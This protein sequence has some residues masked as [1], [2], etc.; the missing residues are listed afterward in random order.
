[1]SQNVTGQ[2]QGSTPSDNSQSGAKQRHSDAIRVAWITAVGAV[3]VAVIG[4]VS[5]FA[6]GLIKAGEAI[7]GPPDGS[8]SAAAATG[9]G[10]PKAGPSNLHFIVPPTPKVARRGIYQGTGNIPSGYDLLV[11]NRSVD[12][13]HQS[14]TGTYSMDGLATGTSSGWNTPPVCAGTTYVEI[15]AVLV[16]S[17]TTRFLKSIIPVVNNVETNGSW[18]SGALP[19]GEKVEPSIFVEPDLSKSDAD[20]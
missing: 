20:C 15:T 12:A 17:S 14:D 18:V 9:S 4:A 5:A 11:F 3:I 16:P 1:V 13:D 19:A 2:P 10:N 7:T 6:G 8:P